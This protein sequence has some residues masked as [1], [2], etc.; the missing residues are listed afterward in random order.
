MR[1]SQVFDPQ[2]GIRLHPSSPFA[3]ENFR[4]LRLGFDVPPTE[5][6]EAEGE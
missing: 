6:I 3:R 2:H 1:Q 4:G 5:P